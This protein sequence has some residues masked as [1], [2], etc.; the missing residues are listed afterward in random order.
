PVPK[1]V[2][3][4]KHQSRQPEQAADQQKA[5]SD[6]KNAADQSGNGQTHAWPSRRRGCRSRNIEFGVHFGESYHYTWH[7]FMP[8]KTN[9]DTP[10]VASVLALQNYLGELER[11]GKKINSIDMAGDVDLEFVQKL[12]ARFAECGHGVSQEVNS[13]S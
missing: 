6:G 7:L 11:I 3:H 5:G 9:L 13:L 12:M 1:E 4:R 10:L 8:D 2:H